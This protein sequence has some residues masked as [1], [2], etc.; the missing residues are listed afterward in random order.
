MASTTYLG[1]KYLNIYKNTAFTGIAT[2]YLALYTVAPTVAG[3][4]TEVSGGSY[5][6]QSVTLG[7]PAS[8]SVTNSADITYTAMPAC[9]VV[10]VGLFDASTAGN[11]LE[12]ATLTTSSTLASGDS[13]VISTGQLT[14]GVS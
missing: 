9:T 5:A 3:G 2:V 6:R 13:F 8:Q 7:T 12:F 10:A 1:N 11:L 14:L 4:G